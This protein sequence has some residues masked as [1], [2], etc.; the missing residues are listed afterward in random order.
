MRPAARHR[1]ITTDKNFF[2]S[3][4]IV[5]HTKIHI[6]AIAREIE[7]ICGEQLSIMSK[8]IFSDSIINTGRQRELDFVKGI[9]IIAMV[10]CH[11]V[12]YMAEVPGHLGY[13]VANDV[14]GGPMAAPMFMICMGIGLC[15]S[16]RNTPLE[17][18]RRGV[19]LFLLGYIL[20]FSRSSLPFAVG[21]ALG[22]GELLSENLVAGLML[23]DI[24]QFAGLALIFIGICF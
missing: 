5:R 3:L 11:T 6:F 7:Y 10:I 18:V 1:H 14:L 17:I 20:N 22:M 21:Y 23:V 24:L 4:V 2:I 16:H 9:A 13:V 19:W 15:F 8:N 12:L